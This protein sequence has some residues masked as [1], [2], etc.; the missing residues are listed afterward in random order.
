MSQAEVDIETP[1]TAGVV[2]LAKSGRS[3]AALLSRRGWKVI[4]SDRAPIDAPEL[5][6]AGVEVHAPSEDLL[7]EVDLLVRSPGVPDESPVLA[8][9]RRRGV[10]VWSELEL[11]SRCLSNPIVGIT[12]TN[13][14][15]TTTE[16]CAHLLRSAGFAAEACG[17]QGTPISSLVGQIDPDVWL[18]VE[19]SSF[20]LEDAHRFRPFAAALLNLSPDHLD[21]HGD[22]DRYLEA[23]LKLFQNMRPGDLAIVPEDITAPGVLPA[24]VIDGPLVDGAVAW[25]DGGLHLAGV[26]LVAPWSDV[27]LAGAHNRFNAMVAAALCLRA[28][29]DPE[30]LAAGLASFPGVPHRLEVVGELDGV[31]FVNDSKATNPEAAAAALDAYDRRV[32]LIAG[33]SAKG[34]P[35]DS[36]A[37]AT[38]GRLASAHLIGETAPEIADALASVGVE[39]TIV[40]D[41]ESAVSAAA[42]LALPGDVVLLAPACASFDQ[43][44]D[45][46]ARGDAFREAARSLGAGPST[47][48]TA[49]PASS[50]G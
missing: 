28:G 23:K 39:A 35:F 32:H 24:R 9:C 2:G 15:T 11:A 31:L 42:A 50:R 18:C 41:L 21:R 1:G 45:Y 44:S 8:D 37:A 20:Q 4:A 49:E 34:T 7:G 22:M 47:S 25:S 38:Q 48:S 43:F 14:K 27:A 3:A 40:E 29:A 17:N 6:D 33:G 5:A 19:C 26:G 36:L 30:G 16:L 46:A 13:G 10:P 12:G